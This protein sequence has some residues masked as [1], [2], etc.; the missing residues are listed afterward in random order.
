VCVSCGLEAC[1]RGRLVGEYALG[2]LALSC[3]TDCV[4]EAREDAQEGGL[5]WVVR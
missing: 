5:P 4:W 2:A 1:A 3:A